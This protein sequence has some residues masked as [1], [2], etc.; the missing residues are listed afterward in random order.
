[1]LVMHGLFGNLGTFRYLAMNEKIKSQVTSHLIDARN[2]GDSENHDRMD[3]LSMAMDLRRYIKEKGLEG[4][5]VVL[6]GQSMGGK[7]AMTFSGLFPQLI[8]GLISI[9]QPPVNRNLYPELNAETNALIGKAMKLN[10]EGMTYREASNY[11]A[12][13]LK[14]HR[15]F[16][17]SLI[18]CLDRK[19][20]ATATWK[21]NLEAINRSHEELYGFEK[22]GEYEGR[23][24]FLVGKESFQ[25]SIEKDRRFYV[26]VFPNIKSE[27]IIHI[28]NAGHWLHYEKQD[29]TIENV[30]KFIQS[31]QV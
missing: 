3:Y 14:D 13:E 20:Q 27:D 26:H 4:Q 11:I 30:A 12:T 8:S 31:L 18:M 22:Y 29:E 16:A 1:M 10:I 17:S 23:V 7:V 5:K 28:E 25:Y 9:D 2:H 19:N 21:I 6:L 15:A 24:M